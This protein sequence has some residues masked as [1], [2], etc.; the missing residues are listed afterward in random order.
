MQIHK[1]IAIYCILFT[2]G[3]LVVEVEVVVVEVEV[4]VVEVEVVVVEVEVVVVE[5]M[6]VEVDVRDGLEGIEVSISVDEMIG[7]G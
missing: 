5:V 4:V 1:K 6:V 3:F 2:L 7:M